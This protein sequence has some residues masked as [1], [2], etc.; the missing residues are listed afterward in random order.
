MAVPVTDPTQIERAVEA[1]LT[2]RIAAVEAT[3]RQHDHRGLYSDIVLTVAITRG[4]DT[5]IGRA[6]FRTDVVVNV[7]LSFADAGGEEARRDGINPLVQG[8]RRALARKRLELDITDILPRGWE[9]VTTEE[10][11]E[12]NRIAYN[13]EFDTSFS[14]RCEDPGETVPDLLTI[15]I[16]YFLKPGDDIA[17]AGDIIQTTP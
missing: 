16:D 5:P 15:G 6:A 14:W 9:D 11:W 13:I 1:F 8:I 7:L 4:K 3:A 17:D 2:D 10:L 12:Q